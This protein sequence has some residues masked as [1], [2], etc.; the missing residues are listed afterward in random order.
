[1]CLLDLLRRCELKVVV[2]HVNHKV[3]SESDEEYRL[4]E[5]YSKDNNIPFEGMSILG[6]INGNFE[7][8]AREIRYNFFEEILTK[9]NA[10]YLF[11]AHHGD[12]LV[13]TILM[14]IGRGASFGGY[15]GFS[16]ES[17]FRGKRKVRPL[18]FVTKKDIL[19]YNEKYGINLK[20]G[21]YCL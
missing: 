21:I 2:A 10:N 1:M 5:E 15:A 6:E 19:E 4:L 14:R 11:T 13:E 17:E 3:R 7:S 8:K 18:I 20:K 12:D 9:Y 16:E